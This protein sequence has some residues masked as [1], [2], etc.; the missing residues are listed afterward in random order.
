M[1]EGDA[2]DIAAE[3]IRQLRTSG[4]VVVTTSEL[5]RLQIANEAVLKRRSDG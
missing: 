3:L 5:E 4:F 1:D 2:P